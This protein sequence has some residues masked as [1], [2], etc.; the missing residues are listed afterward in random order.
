MTQHPLTTP[1]ARSAIEAAVAGHL[2][3]AWH[4]DNTTDL[5]ERSSH[6]AMI[7]R[8]NG[9]AVF[10]KL[11]SGPGAQG[12]V[13]AELA[14]LHL[15]ESLAGV[16]VPQAVGSGSVAL[17]DGDS[18]L[19][20]EALAER[21]PKDRTPADWESIGRTLARVHSVHGEQFGL[22]RS[23]FFGPLPQ[24]NTPIPG[25]T[26][27]DFYRERRVLP[28][29]ATAVDA[30]SV[31]PPTARGTERLLDRLDDLAGP[32]PEPALLHGDAQH[33]N[34]VST[35]SG[36]V[37]IDPSPYFGHPELDLALLDY[38]TPVPDATF[39]AYAEIQ[40]TAVDFPERRELWRIFAYLAI[41]T[42]DG[43]SAFGRSFVPRLAAAFD[44][45]R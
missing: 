35:Q 39:A 16:A 31:D 21:V 4:M 32:D 26:W 17:P 45:Y 7:L 10:A 36:A 15:I 30:G 19:L 40:P 25:G 20:F 38:F 23:G 27:A 13:A 5:A 2:G 1:L 28:W 29:L 24:D 41:L 33:H 37:V 8:G 18:V 22:D 14:D 44:R 43:R 9:L 34:F 42:V 6:P 3:R 12:Q 11:A